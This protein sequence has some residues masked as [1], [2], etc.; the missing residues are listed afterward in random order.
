MSNLISINNYDLHIFDGKPMIKDISLAEKLGY[1]EPKAIRRL[2]KRMLTK[3]Q[4]KAENVRDTVTR[5]NNG[6]GREVSE[7]YLDEKTTLK[8][9]TKSETENAD[10]IT[11]EMIDVFIAYRSG[12][13]QQS[14]K[15]ALDIMLMQCQRLV[16]QE[17]RQAETDRKLSLVEDKQ[18]HVDQRLEQLN[19]DT[20]YRTISAHGKIIGV[21]F[22]L[23]EAKAL[24]QKAKK[25]CDEK[26]LTVGSIADERFG[27]VNSYPVEILE[28]L[29]Y[30]AS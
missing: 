27:R 26:G 28:E 20:G 1:T 24:G 16:D 13:L 30:S 22:P 4:L 14:P 10:A 19:P 21:K 23:N 5:I 3:L 2:I 8:V 25:L 12:E 18:E 6:K 9:I 11:D 15:T 7:Y 29:I 17:R